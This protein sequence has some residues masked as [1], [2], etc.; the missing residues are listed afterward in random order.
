MYR[1]LAG[2][3]PRTLRGLA[4]NRLVFGRI[5]C[6]CVAVGWRGVLNIL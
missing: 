5:V 6:E 3:A 4:V 1:R 2:E